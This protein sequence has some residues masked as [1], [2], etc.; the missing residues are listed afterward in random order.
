MI[1]KNHEQVMYVQTLQ[2]RQATHVRIA[3]DTY[4]NERDVKLVYF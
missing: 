3:Q 1:C 4:N 2:F